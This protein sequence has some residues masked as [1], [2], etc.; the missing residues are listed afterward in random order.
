MINKTKR[1][2]KQ[3]LEMMLAKLKETYGVI[4][5][6]VSAYA[7]EILETKRYIWDNTLD[8][9]EKAAN[10]IAVHETIYFAENALERKR[11][12]AK[13]L[14]SPYFGRIDFKEERE[15]QETAYYLGVHSFTDDRKNEVLIHDWRAPIAGLF[16]DFETGPAGYSAPLGQINGQM[17]LKRQ[18]KIKNGIM[19]YM[20]ESS[21]NIGDEVLQKEL[22]RTSD[23]KMKNIVAT[24]QK[25]QNSIIRNEKSDILI[26]QGV[27]GSGKTSVALH[28]VAYLLYRYKGKLTSK[29]ILFISPNRVFAD[30]IS[31]VLPELGEEEIPEMGMDEIAAGEIPAKLKI[32][33]FYQQ[34][35]ALTQASDEDAIGR[36]QY[37]ASREFLGRLNSFLAYAE[38]E[39]FTPAS[40]TLNGVIFSKEYLLSRYRALKKMPVK[41]RLEKMAATL[42]AKS[43]SAG[44][45]AEPA[46]KKNVKTA[47]LKMFK[48]QDALSLYKDFFAYIQKPEMFQLPQD[49]LEY[50][51]VFPYIYVKI[52]FEGM[53]KEYAPVKHLLVDE[54][55]DYT[56]VQYAV[57]AR[58][59]LSKMTILGDSSQAVNPYSSTSAE[60]LKH[61]FPRADVIELS[62]SYRSTLEITQ[63]AQKI[64]Y[65]NKLVSVE[66]HGEE[67][68]IKDCGHAR[69]QY[70]EIQ[71]LIKQFFR[72]GF[73]SLGIVCKTQEQ[74]EEIHHR[75]KD[76]NE[77]VFLF[78][79]STAEYREGIIVTSAHLAKGLEFDQ[80]IVSF[81]SSAVYQ[82]E[83]DR[84]LLY[85]A[86]TLAMHKLDLTYFGEL[87]ALIIEWGKI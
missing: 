51:D 24:I 82:T 19:E 27:A 36:I 9:A 26:I 23:E 11:K 7:G 66:R 2:E 22:S 39:Y 79:D 43:K 8:L 64:K 32:E 33:N 28:R 48:F 14:S 85:I 53:N 29:D 5:E 40:V 84:S 3:Y 69:G 44:G 30:Y 31:N 4:E 59:F 38:T 63:F 70:A 25:E 86:C 73:H 67:P 80:V 15:N 52:F 6:R 61:V 13:L 21:L 50:A 76:K 10:R 75:I 83:L 35:A 58:L 47:F 56:P 54:M 77:R 20:L 57:L 46:A 12:I 18:Y 87:T 45:K 72:S 60:V 74:A 68:T 81:V 65:N 78:D 49:T 17:T 71:K 41:K 1:E 55:Q 16:Y 34:V 42:I 62:K 37:K